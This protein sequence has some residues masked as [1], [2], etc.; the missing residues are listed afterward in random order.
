MKEHDDILAK[1]DA[2][3]SKL[4]VLQVKENLIDSKIDALNVRLDVFENKLNILGVGEDSILLE[5][6]AIKSKVNSLENVPVTEINTK[7][8]DLD[9]KSSD[10]MA[11]VLNVQMS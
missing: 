7:L 5:L 4:N 9:T 8:A 11:A 10:I 3:D 2:L 1:L 6:D